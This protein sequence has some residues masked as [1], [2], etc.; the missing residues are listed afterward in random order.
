M[1]PK[2]L[3]AH[4]LTKEESN[5]TLTAILNP[6]RDLKGFIFCTLNML[7]VPS[8]HSHH[9]NPVPLPALSG[10]VGYPLVGAHTH[11][12]THT[13]AHTHTHIHFSAMT[14]LS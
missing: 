4:V 2:S 3:V 12:H 13:H 10:S 14:I 9:G 11:I 8:A 1:G 6:L 7:T 5:L